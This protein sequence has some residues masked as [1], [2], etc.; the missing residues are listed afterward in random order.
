MK[1]W[2]L[3]SI[4]LCLLS[5]QASSKAPKKVLVDE[6]RYD[7]SRMAR[8]IVQKLEEEAD[9]F[10][11]RPLKLG[12]GVIR[13]KSGRY[14]NIKK[15]KSDLEIRLY[16]SRTIRYSPLSPRLSKSSARSLSA[17]RPPDFLLEASIQNVVGE[18]DWLEFRFQIHEYV[19][20]RDLWTFN[21]LYKVR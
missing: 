21:R 9:S 14:V 4:S 18:R 17:W 3:L 19:G 7:P 10:P 1:I 11:E 6:D 2:V 13:N 16:R 20:D 12:V 15:L 5:C 8:L